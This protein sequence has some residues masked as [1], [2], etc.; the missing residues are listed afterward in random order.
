MFASTQ[1]NSQNG[2]TILKK[3]SFHA[4]R[5]DTANKNIPQNNKSILAPQPSIDHV[6]F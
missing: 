6:L 4:T 3:K 1:L 2:Q 5:A